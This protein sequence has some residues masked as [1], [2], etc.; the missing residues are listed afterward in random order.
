MARKKEDNL[1][2][3]SL[4]TDFFY[5]RHIKILRAERGN[6]GV[7][8]YLYLLCEI[9][10]KKG[11][12]IEYDDDMIA[13]ATADLG[14]PMNEIRQIIAF[15][16]KRSMLVEV[17]ID[18][19]SQLFKSD[20]V[21][22]SRS[23]QLQYQES[24]KNKGRQ[25]CVEVLEDLWVLKKEETAGHIKVVKNQINTVEMPDITCISTVEKA[26]NTVKIP[27]IKSNKN[28]LK[29]SKEEGAPAEPAYFSSPDVNELFLDYLSQRRASKL[30]VSDKTIAM[31]KKKLEGFSEKEQKQALEDAIIGGYKSL[32]PKRGKSRESH[33]GPGEIATPEERKQAYYDLDRLEEEKLWEEINN[34]NL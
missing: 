15:L 23:I 18:E 34:A 13:A 10:G 25:R 26:I 24:T 22:T 27:Q 19:T 9:Y 28:K 14:I 5:N 7:I 21:I 32:Y 3:F 12:Y 29:K 8:F 17:K 1:R 4:D 20:K 2:Y 33:L 16:L 31:L 6:N 30:S 11:Y